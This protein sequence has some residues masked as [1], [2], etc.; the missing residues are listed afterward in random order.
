MEAGVRQGCPLAPLLYLFVAQALL[1]WLQKQKVGI[2][3]R[4]D[5]EELATAFQ[6]ADDT[7]VLLESDAKVPGFIA[8]MDTFGR[9]TGQRL[10]LSKVELLRV[11]CL[12][13]APGPAAA[14]AGAAPAVPG[15]PAAPAVPVAPAAPAAPAAPDVPAAPAAAAA[16]TTGPAAAAAPGPGVQEQL[17]GLKVVTAATA[18]SVPFSSDPTRLRLDWTARMREAR[19]RLRRVAHLGLSVFGR[20]SAASAYCTS[21]VTWHME[22]SGLPDDIAQELERLVARVVDRRLAPDSTEKRL[23]GIPTELLYGHPTTGGFGALPIRQHVRGRHA[24]W[25]ARLAAHDDIPAAPQPQPWCVAYDVYLRAHH[26]SLRPSST[27]TAVPVVEGAG[28]I[29]PSHPLPEDTERTVSALGW[30]PP[31]QVLTEAPEPGAWCF[32]APLWGN[33]LLTPSPAAASGEQEEEDSG[34]DGETAVEPV[35]GL[36]GDIPPSWWSAA[37]AHAAQLASPG[38]APVPAPSTSEVVRTTIMPRMGWKLSGSETLKVP[39]AKLSV[40]MA[41]SMQLDDVATRRADLH[42]DY[43]RAAQGLPP[44]AV[45]RR[46]DLPAAAAATLGAIRDTLARLC[47]AAGKLAYAVGSP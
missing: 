46:E 28:D 4:P 6:F 21:M 13:A 3:L 11:G 42:E 23:T 29:I 10:N 31:V 19:R 2:R 47:A 24:T 34:S 9:A 44:R 27:L 43:E 39:L 17:C 37:Q 38:P 35:P 26:P 1:C 7:K 32:T 41:T 12:P 45:V 20:A 15:M 30:L 40:R 18:L 22:H 5:R 8:V 36:V 16:P 25:A 33:P 14:V